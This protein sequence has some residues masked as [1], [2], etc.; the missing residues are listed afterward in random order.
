M[1]A[2]GV[3]SE[4]QATVLGVLESLS[5]DICNDPDSC[6]NSICD[7][8]SVALGLT[9]VQLVTAVVTGTFNA[10]VMPGSLIEGFFNGTVPAGSIDF[11]TNA[12]QKSRLFNDLVGF[13]GQ[14]TILGCTDTDY[15]AYNASTDLHA[16]HQD[17]PIGTAEFEAFN[18]DLIGVLKASG[19]S[20]PDQNAVYA[21]LESTKSAVCNQP[22]CTGNMAAGITFVFDVVPKVHHPFTG[23]G[24]P[25]GFEVDGLEGR[26]L[27]LV[28]GVVY[29]FTNNGIC[30]HPLYITSSEIG[31]G[32]DEVDTGVT[33]PGGDPYSVCGGKSLTFTPAASEVGT[34]LY[35][36]CRNHMYMGYTISV[37]TSQSNIPVTTGSGTVTLGAPATLSGAVSTT[38]GSTAST[39][40]AAEGS[41]YS[42]VPSIL[43]VVAMIAMML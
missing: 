15:P 23:M 24:F 31:A 40:A 42:L 10:A 34:T 4:D 26:P 27:N 33:F 13:F 19:V 16:I 28:V 20:V 8:Y 7:R 25:S 9:N 30:S 29:T 39:T 1:A 11:V 3:S 38:G 14:T 6:K 41:A 35:Y 12:A 21:I 43:L 22:D 18:S 36:Q 32:A 17:M 5:N 37:Y 2:D